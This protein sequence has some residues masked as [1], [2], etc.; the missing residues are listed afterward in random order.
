MGT[1][2]TEWQ[3]AR[4]SYNCLERPQGAGEMVQSGRLYEGQGMATPEHRA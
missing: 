3:V 2:A 1:D 4:N